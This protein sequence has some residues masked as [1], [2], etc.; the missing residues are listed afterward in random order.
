MLPGEPS[1]VLLPK[2]LTEVLKALPMGRRMRWA[3]RD[4][5]FSRPIHWIVL[6]LGNSPIEA[7]IFGIKSN[8]FSYGHRFHHPHAIPIPSPEAYETLLS[9]EGFVIADF[10][11][12]R[13][14]IVSMIEKCL[15]PQQYQAL[16]NSDLLDEV[17]GLVEWPVILLGEFDSAFLEIPSE[18][19]ITSM[20]N[21]QKCF[22]VI[23]QNHTLLNKFLITSNI[24]SQVPASVVAGNEWVM[25][26]RLVIIKKIKKFHFLHDARV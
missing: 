16:W 23:D 24:Q 4:D 17:T 1:A 10:D 15:Q 22:A 3:D 5:T 12:R 25:H 18:V 7:E 19:L 20:Q 21:H 14:A 9:R 2:M 8:H 11:E 6:L 26:A 13:K